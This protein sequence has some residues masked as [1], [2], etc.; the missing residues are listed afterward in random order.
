MWEN[1]FQVLIIPNNDKKSVELD[2][3][4][5]RKKIMTIFVQCM[6]LVELNKVQF[7]M[8]FKHFDNSQVP[9]KERT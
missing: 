8:I 9:E 4:M 6:I 3:E 7:F 5:L 1:W 2:C